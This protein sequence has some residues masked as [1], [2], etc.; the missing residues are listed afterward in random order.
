MHSVAAHDI[1]FT[2]LLANPPVLWQIAD[3]NVLSTGSFKLWSP[4]SHQY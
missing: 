2:Q 4:Y 3:E 1:I